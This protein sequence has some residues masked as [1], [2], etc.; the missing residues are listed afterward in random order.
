MRRVVGLAGVVLV[1]LVVASGCVLTGSW[2]AL[3]PAAPPAP[4]PGV[5]ADP[6]FA[7]VSCP[8]DDFCLA[9]GAVVGDDYSEWIPLAE[10]WDGS[11]W[12]VVD[13][14][15]LERPAPPGE[16]F[17]ER[18]DHV[19]CRAADDCVAT[20]SELYDDGN[21]A[22]IYGRV[23]TWDGADWTEIELDL[24]E[25][26]QPKD[27]D[28]SPGGH[29]IIWEDD[30]GGYAIWDGTSVVSEDWTFADGPGACAGQDLCVRNAQWA[31]FAEHWDGSTWT[32]QPLPEEEFVASSIDCTSPTMC[33]AVGIFDPDFDEVGELTSA[34]WDGTAWTM[35]AVP[36]T[37]EGTFDAV[38]CVGGE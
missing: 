26:E 15:D 16:T 7:D 33:V 3:T 6:D 20:V 4:P 23:F 9:V 24:L 14:G 13:T 25:P 19:S 2:A 36:V 22:D 1:V 12:S 28:C 34:K 17:T 37:D 10:T 11:S 5:T 21:A 29:C 27:V 18:L 38:S 32:T 35:P 8:T 30:L 31:G